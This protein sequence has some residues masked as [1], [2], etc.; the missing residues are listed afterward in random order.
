MGEREDTI[1]ALSTPRG[2]SGVAVIRISG[3][4]A[5]DALRTL[6]I[7]D[8]ISPR[9]ATCKILRDSSGHP[10]DQ[11]VVLYFPA[12]GSFTG[13]DVIELQ[14][15]GSIAVIRRLYDML[16]TVIRIANPGEF[17][18]RAYLNGK[19][20]LTMAEGISDLINA[21]TEAQLRQAVAQST[22]SL[23]RQYSSWRNMLIDIISSLEACIDFPEDVDSS[24]VLGGI[25]GGISQFRE[26]LAL[27]LDDNH[28]G[29][30]LR[31]GIRVV[32]LGEPNAGK[33]TLFNSL[34]RRNA[35]IVSAQPGTTRDVLEVAIDI[36][37]Y[38][39]VIV[40]TAGIRDSSDSIEQEGIRRALN[41][42]EHADVKIVMCPYGTVFQESIDAISSPHDER[43]VWVLSKADNSSESGPVMLH[44]RKFHPISVHRDIGVSTLLQ[45]IKEKS[46]NSFPGTEDVCITSHRHRSHLQKALQFL[47]A[48]THDMPVEIL[49]EHLRLASQEIGR[50][51][52][53]VYGDDILNDIFSKFCIGK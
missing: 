42:A 12:P 38:P 11:A 27:Y 6:G 47:S 18:L 29:E 4:G 17:S 14:V 53:V 24:K 52:G 25:Y 22:G 39:F 46:E 15:H 33:S 13:E 9:M 43:T 5:L 26:N 37:G 35:A 50:V 31:N 28:R 8:E 30:I 44:G 3:T 48:I 45:L 16:H 41:A 19:I 40:D 49:A 23:K 34:A 1:F 2:K 10:I 51:T 7:Y 21:E 32:I 20:D 36:D